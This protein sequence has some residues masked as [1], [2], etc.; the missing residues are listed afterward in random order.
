MDRSWWLISYILYP[1][2]ENTQY[3][4]S[5]T[6]IVSAFSMEEAIRFFDRNK[7]RKRGKRQ[8]RIVS[9]INYGQGINCGQEVYITCS[10]YSAWTTPTYTLYY[11]G[12]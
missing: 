10:T 7:L 9:V 1:T 6:E 4:A 5:L 12:N 3:T 11:S 2:N 8:G